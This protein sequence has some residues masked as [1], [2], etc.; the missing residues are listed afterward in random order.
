MNAR[1]FRLICGVLCFGATAAHALDFTPYQRFPQPAPFSYVVS[2]AA[3]PDGTLLLWNGDTVYRQKFPN[4]DR[5]AAIASGYAGDTGFLAIASDGHTAYLGAGFSGDIYRLDVNSPQNFSPASIVANESHFSGTLLTDDLV[6][7]DASTP[8]FS[9]TQLLILSISN[10]TIGTRTVVSK[11]SKYAHPKTV[12]V[13]KPLF[14]YSSA[15]TV[16][17]ANGMLYA[18][19]GNTRE[20]RAFSVAAL[21]N[22]YNSASTLDWENDGTLIG[23]PGQFFSNGV[24]GITPQGALIIG[25]SEGYLQPGGIHLVDPRLDDPAQA[26]ILDTYDPAG[27]QGFY[28]VIYNPVTNVITA[29]EGVQAYASVPAFA[30][31]PAADI[32]ALA[33]LAGTLLTLGIRHPGRKSRNM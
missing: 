8:D 29:I 22:A 31:V 1:I 4:V 16:D 15:L 20:L 23:T 25:G 5:Y 13:D 19:D 30:P 6:I 32:A 26:T 7:L 18:M 33:L 10:K 27:N 2:G 28:T 24:S 12:V 17:E 3:L 14:S 9:R 11:S 21:I